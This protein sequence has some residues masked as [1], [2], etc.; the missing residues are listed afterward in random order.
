MLGLKGKNTNERV[1]PIE[2]VDPF[3]AVPVRNML[4]W[5]VEKVFVKTGQNV[6][7]GD[8]LVELYGTEL[9]EVENRLQTRLLT[10]TCRAPGD[11]TIGE[12]AAKPGAL[13]KPSVDGLI[14]FSPANPADA[15]AKRK[16]LPKK[17]FRIPNV[18]R[19]GFTGQ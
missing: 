14:V 6:K 11:G 4:N 16:D 13:F 2:V 17:R 5:R 3:D 8:A 9:V 12:I 18:E 15:D 7:R 1:R 19:R 10:W